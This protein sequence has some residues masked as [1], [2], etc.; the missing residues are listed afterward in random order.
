MQAK[1]QKVQQEKAASKILAGTQNI[2]GLEEKLQVW[3]SCSNCLF[4]ILS[5]YISVR[6]PRSVDTK[7]AL[8]T[9]LF[10]DSN[11]RG[12]ASFGMDG[13]VLLNRV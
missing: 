8:L 11:P 10:Q 13:Y 3:C 7:K 12:T 4:C 5:I 1:T 2:K 6:R 9:H